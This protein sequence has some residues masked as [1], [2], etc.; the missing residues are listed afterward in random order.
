MMVI[1]HL[2]RIR[3]RKCLLVLLEP[4]SKSFEENEEASELHEAKEVLPIKLPATRKRR[5][6]CIQAKKGSTNQRLAYRRSRRPSCVARL[7]RLDR[8][9]ATHLLCVTRH[10]AGRYHRR[11][12]MTV[13]NHVKVKGQLGQAHFMTIC[14]VR[15]H[16]Q[17][18]AMAIDYRHD[19]HALSTFGWTDLRASALDHRPDANRFRRGAYSKQSCGFSTLARRFLRK[20]IPNALPL[21]VA[22]PNHL[23]FIADRTRSTIGS[24]LIDDRTSPILK[25]PRLI[26]QFGFMLSFFPG[27]PSGERG[28]A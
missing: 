21:L 27:E 5:C 13:F 24:K 19:F 12:P 4:I 9:G 17:R 11:S 20:T 16:R 1:G 28:P 7:R 23:T 15:T 22:E 2:Q 14:G 10:R 26:A 3:R 18:Q 6:H 25:F 8:C